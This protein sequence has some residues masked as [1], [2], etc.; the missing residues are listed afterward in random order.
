MRLQ[1]NDKTE[2]A[3]S[4]IKRLLD[5][6]E[7]DQ[8]CRYL[9]VLGIDDDE[10]NSDLASVVIQHLNK[11]IES[12]S[13]MHSFH[14][15]TN[16]TRQFQ[17]YGEPFAICRVWD[18]MAVE[19]WTHGADW[20][21]L[22][23]DDVEITC[24][25]HHRAFYRSFLDISSRLNVPFGFGCPFWNDISFPGFPTFPCVGKIHYEIFRGLIH[26]HRKDSF[27]NQDLDLYLHHLY[28]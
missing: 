5:A 13:Q 28:L 25:F 1:Q 14:I 11:H 2:E 16:P 26:E 10:R 23:G 27:V 12:T 15:V 19:A 17:L 4:S 21:L 9:L 18:R 20:V 24:P 3:T 22:L 6:I 7:K 8:L